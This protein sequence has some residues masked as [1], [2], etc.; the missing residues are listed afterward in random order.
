MFTILGGDGKEY[1]P[2]SAEQIRGWMKAGRANL[3][4]K[5]RAAGTE[6]WKRLG[7]H[8]EFA[9]PTDAPP[10]MTAFTPPEASSATPA[11]PSSN[12]AEQGQR[13]LARI[14]DW[15]IEII[16]VI[17]GAVILGSEV[18]KLAMTV[19]Q[20]KEPDFDQLDVP[21]LILG[22]SILAFMSLSLLVVQVWML[23]VRGQ[24]I[25]KRIVGIKVVKA[26]GSAAGFVNGWLMR[27]LLITAI[28]MAISMIPIIGPIMLRPA[29]HIVDWCLIFRDDQRCLHDQM[30][31][32]IVVKA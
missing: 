4:T 2:A 12:R 5:A 25:G 14:I 6:E 22:G 16:C 7:D 8:A 28:G 27:E 9:P 19:S 26:D 13:L 20:G 29:F 3:D 18:I 23:T 11:V 24:T 15:I 21:K 10:V 1:G 32:T 17:P 30:A 31:G